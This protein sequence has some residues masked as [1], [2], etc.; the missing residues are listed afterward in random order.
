[1]NLPAN[2]LQTAYVGFERGSV[3]AGGPNSV[4]LPAASFSGLMSERPIRFVLQGQAENS[5]IKNEMN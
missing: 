3:W 1:M 2:L 4:Q 5:N